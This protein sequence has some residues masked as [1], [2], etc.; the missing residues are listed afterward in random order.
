MIFIVLAP[1]VGAIINGLFFATGLRNVLFRDTDNRLIERAVGI[2]ACSSVLVSALLSTYLFVKLIALPETQRT[3]TEVLFTW[4][5]SSDLNIRFEFLFDPLSA[6]MCLVVTWVGFLIHV[7]SLGYMHGDSGFARYFSYLNLFLFFMLIL[8]LG[9]NFPMMFVGWE[10]V[11]LASYLLIGFWYNDSD[12]AY[13]GRKA[14]VVNRIG[15]FGFILG[16]FLIFYVFGSLNYQDVFGKIADPNF[17]SSISTVTITA[18]ALLLFVGAV[19][20]SAQFPLYVWLPDA[21]AGPTP[22]SALIHA[23]TM[24][25]AGVYMISRC[26]AIFSLSPTA[27][28]VVLCISTFTALMAALI[29]ITQNDIKKVLAYSTVSQ[30]GYMFMATGVGAYVFAIFHL[31][32]HAF[33]KALLFLGSGSVIHALSGEQDIRRMG[34]LR[35]FIP[36]TS[37]TFL[38]G[39]LAI[40]GVPFFSGFFSKDEILGAIYHSGHTTFWIIG[41]VTAVL[42]AFYMMRLYILTFEGTPRMTEEIK[43]HVHESPPTMTVPLIILAILSIFGGYIGVPDFMA[44][45]LGLK[46]I[47]LIEHFF[48]PVIM[49]A[50]ASS[51]H[52]GYGEHSLLSHWTLVTISIAA[53]FS[54]IF[55]AFLLYCLN[56]SLRGKL[57]AIPVLSAFYRFSLNKFYID[58]LYAKIFV[59]PYRHFSKEFAS[60]DRNVID[61]MVN[62]IGFRVRCFSSLFLKIT[63]PGLLRAYAFTIF[64]G[65]VAIVTALFLM[66]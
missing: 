14:F 46:S 59:E 24:V 31:V 32:T 60:F 12:K 11:G 38:I 35:K 19:G 37:W 58:E 41:V 10:G 9:N 50:T 2:I 47:N 33:F 65:V 66:K 30:L 20:K 7:Y 21:M 39:T 29:A 5:T 15:D 42:T 8:I 26:N 57:S 49:K 56:P 27:Q 13:A 1:I 44:E 18:I 3:I 28:Y 25:T 23:A 43:K 62:G 4:I 51:S 61:G 63:Q 40:S 55:I 36:V 54:G 64:I 48:E 16:I 22:V 34:G 52:T 6:V 45:A 17:V 53:A